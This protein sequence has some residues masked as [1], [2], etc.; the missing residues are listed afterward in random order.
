MLVT[1]TIPP[2][3]EKGS[4]VLE[5]ESGRAVQASAFVL[6]RSLLRPIIPAWAQAGTRQE[7]PSVV[8]TPDTID[9]KAE[10]LN[11]KHIIIVGGGMTAAT[12]AVSAANKGAERVTLVARRYCC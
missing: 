9:V 10:N 12:L 6:A 1:C 3:G 4:L 2:D 8:R 11:G 5:L 7:L